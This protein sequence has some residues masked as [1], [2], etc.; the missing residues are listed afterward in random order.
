MEV[1]LHSIFQ[2]DVASGQR[3]APST[4]LL[5]AI[6][7]DNVPLLP[8]PAI[9]SARFLLR[10]LGMAPRIAQSVTRTLYLLSYTVSYLILD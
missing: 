1:W 9:R 5:A 2:V 3:H 10:P 8:P 4:M 7:Q 6:Q